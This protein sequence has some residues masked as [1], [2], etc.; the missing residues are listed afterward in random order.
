MHPEAVQA[1]VAADNAGV[2]D[3]AGAVEVEKERVRL[4]RE[5]VQVERDLC[6]LMAALRA[7]GSSPTII[8]EIGR[9]DAR[10][11]D[12]AERL[13]A[14]PATPRPMAVNADATDLYRRRVK[15]VATL[16]S[17]RALAPK[18]ND[19]LREVVEAIVVTPGAG[20]TWRVEVRGS[21]PGLFR[22]GRSPTAAA[23]SSGRDRGD[24]FSSV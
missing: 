7:A 4:E 12:L 10:Q 19:L 13:A 3:G 21:L 24:V 6:N 14:L 11:N 18:V 20:K 9:A 15:E 22:W 1:F 8:A 2:R 23:L 16:F 17:D 5:A